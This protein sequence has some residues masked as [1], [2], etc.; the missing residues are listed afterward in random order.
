MGLF[1]FIGD[2]VSSGFK[3]VT[4]QREGIL[5]SAIDSFV[6]GGA[7]ARDVAGGLID[8]VTGGGGDSDRNRPRSQPSTQ[9][10]QYPQNLVQQP[11]G[12][13]PGITSLGPDWR[14][15]FSWDDGRF[16]GDFD[17]PHGNV[18]VGTGGDE[19]AADSL[20]DW[21]ST[22]TGLA[23]ALPGVLLGGFLIAKA[24]D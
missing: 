3:Q 14:G 15:D 13:V 12:E 16:E 21:F 2:Q 20:S 7:A 19:S 5:G 1:S 24:L 4:G 11:A 17:T 10:V 22:G 18:S 8:T 23:I 9:P 6:P